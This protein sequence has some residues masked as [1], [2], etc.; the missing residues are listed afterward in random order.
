MSFHKK[1][2]VF[3]CFGLSLLFLSSNVFAMTTYGYTSSN[4]TNIVN[5]IAGNGSYTTSMNVD[6]SFTV[7]T[8]LGGDLNNVDISSEAGFTFSFFDGRTT[9]SSSDTASTANR[10]L[11]STNSS[12][13]ITGWDI[14]L[15]LNEATW[16]QPGDIRQTIVAFY[17]GAL[18]NNGGEIIECANVDCD[19]SPNRDTGSILGVGVPNGEWTVVP[20]P[21][22]AWLFGSGLLGLVGMARR[23][24]S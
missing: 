15:G 2:T 22:A 14:D 23:K 20:V 9:I 18:S 12:G 3:H 16:T 21:A 11:I 10:F 17:D 1:T 13:E 7:D 19:F 24:K 5:D 8:S 4:F 6:G